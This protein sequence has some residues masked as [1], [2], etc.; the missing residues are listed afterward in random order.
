[1]GRSAE[2][3][4]RVA[5][6]EKFDP[7]KH[8]TSFSSGN[9][10]LG[11][12]KPPEGMRHWVR[13]KGSTPVPVPEYSIPA[14]IAIGS[15]TRGRSYLM[16]EGGAV[17]QT[18]VSWYGP[19]ERWDISPGFRLG[20]TVRRPIASACLYCHVDRVEPIR[21]TEN[22]YREPLFPRQAAIGC[23]RCHG[24]GELHVAERTTKRSPLAVDTSIVNPRHLSPALQSAICEQCHLQGT[25]RV[26]RRGRDMYEFRPGLPFEQ[27]VS[28][29]V[30]HPDIA[31]ANKSVGQFEQMEQSRCFTGSGGK[32]GCTSCHD[33]HNAPKA[34]QWTR[35]T[36]SDV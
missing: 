29:Y 22:R 3:V 4:S 15:G 12:E 25:E 32:L 33:P 9:F 17:W 6:L 10:D 8:H 2:Y 11:V 19:E 35:T 30:R 26:N 18:P 20:S 21:G 36:G 5:S 14:E 13:V 27:F 24:P 7:A 16:V 28:V 23:E 31:E 1:M 34:R